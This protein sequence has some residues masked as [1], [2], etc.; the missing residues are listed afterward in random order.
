MFERFTPEARQIIVLAQEEAVNLRHGYIGT[1]HMLLALLRA[2]PQTSGRVLQG[3]GIT[4]ARVR[5]EVVRLVGE[6]GEDPVSGEM[7]FTPRAKAALE[8]A[9]EESLAGDERAVADP[10]RAGKIEPRHVLLGIAGEG[11]GVGARILREADVPMELIR[12]ELGKA[13]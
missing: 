3:H 10:V 8:R 7:P 13:G 4:S 5:S 11:Q 2:D 12:T 1:E 6:G 9:L